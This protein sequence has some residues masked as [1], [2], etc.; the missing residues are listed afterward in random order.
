MTNS[1]QGLLAAGVLGVVAL[2]SIAPI[3]YAS[4]T[5]VTKNYQWGYIT[6]SYELWAAPN[7]KL[8]ISYASAASWANPFACHGELCVYVPNSMVYPQTGSNACQ[9]YSAGFACSFTV[10]SKA[11]YTSWN[12]HCNEYLCFPLPDRNVWYS[13]SISVSV[14]GGI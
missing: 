1:R 6:V 8:E 5:T 12:L 14:V 2:L 10:T 4:W 13:M 9:T 7:G 11:E 3:A